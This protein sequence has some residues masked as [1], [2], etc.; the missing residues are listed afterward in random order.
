MASGGFVAPGKAE[1]CTHTASCFPPHLSG[2]IMGLYMTT[3]F[4]R[5]TAVVLLLT[6]LD[7][8]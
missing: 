4:N 2:Y 7:L 5:V 3:A 1:S 8:A 6:V